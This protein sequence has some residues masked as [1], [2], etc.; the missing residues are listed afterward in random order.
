MPAAIGYFVAAVGGWGAAIALVVSVAASAYA[1]IAAKRAQAGTQQERKQILRSATAPLNVIYGKNRSAG[2]LTFAEEAYLMEVNEQ[3]Q[4]YRGKTEVLFMVVTHAGHPL[5]KV[6]GYKLNDDDYNRL[7][8]NQ[9][10]IQTYKDGAEVSDPM[11]LKHSPSW[12]ADMI[13]KGIA[14]F[15]ARLQFD[16][17]LFPNGVPNINAL[18]WG[19]EIE[20]PRTGLIQWTDN[21]ALVMLHYLKTYLGYSNDELIIET[22]I[23]AANIC[24]EWVSLPDGA[25]QEARYR[26]GAEFNIDEEPS[27]ILDKMLATMG[28]EWVKVGG[29]L[30]LA[31]AA[32]YGPAV[33]DITEDDLIDAVELQPEVERQDAFNTVRGKFNDAAQDYIETDYPQVSVAEYVAEDGEEIISSLDLEFVQSPWQCQRL[34][35]IAIQRNRY[36]MQVKLPCNLR[37]FKCVPGTVI[38]LRLPGIGLDGVEC[39]VLDWEFSLENG[40]VLVVRRESAAM[41]N[42]AVGRPLEVPPLISSTNEVAAP[43]N[44]RFETDVNND[45]VSGSLHWSN[46]AMQLSHTV[47]KIKAG[48]TVVQTVQVP[49]P[50]ESIA[51]VG[52]AAG[53]YSL[54]AMAV[55]VSGRASPETALNITLAHPVAPSH[56]DVD[57]SSEGLT[58]M[59]H[60][61]DDSQLS[62]NTIFEF[63]FNVID[64]LAGAQRLGQGK[65]L[66]KQGLAPDTQYWFWIYTITPLGRSATPLGIVAR[67]GLVSGDILEHIDNQVS[68]KVAEATEE[69]LRDMGSLTDIRGIAE[70]LDA[71]ILADYLAQG[72]SELDAQQA[73][74]RVARLMESVTLLSDDQQSLAQAVTSLYARFDENAALVQ[75]KDRAQVGYSVKKDGSPGDATSPAAAEMF[76]ETWIPGRAL[77]DSVKLVGIVTESGKTLTVSQYFSALETA[78][79]ELK[80]RAFLG[81]DANGRTTGI[82]ITSDE[83]GETVFQAINFIGDAVSISN[84]DNPA[85]ALLYY[86]TQNKV[87]SVKG[88][89]ILGDGYVIDSEDAIRAKDGGR[90]ETRYKLDPN[91]PETPTGRHPVG[92]GTAMPNPTDKTQIIWASTAFIN[93]DDTLSIT[94]AIPARISGYQGDQGPQGV[95]GIAG[96]NGVTTYTWIK[97]ADSATGAGLSNDP[98]GKAYIGFAYNKTTAAESNTPSDYTWSLVKGEQ[99][100]QGVPGPKGADGVTTYT[101]IKY[102]D[103]SDGTG[104]YDT[105]TVNTKYIGIAVNKT[106]QAESENKADYVWSQFKGDQGAQGLPGA[107]GFSG[108]GFYRLINSNGIWPGD[109]AAN[110]LFYTSFGRYPVIDDVLTFYNANGSTY[111]T[112]RCTDAGNGSTAKWAAAALLLHGDMIA[113]G[114][115]SGSRL[116]AGTEISAPFIRGGQIEIGGVNGT[117]GVDVN[118]GVLIKSAGTNAR[119]EIINDRLQVYDDTGALAVRIGRL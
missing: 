94:W 89:M 62:I 108:A 60:I 90:W 43:T 87:L 81:I 37:G 2:T 9:A 53:N 8:P 93:A 22:F 4:E 110:G 49:S 3:G 117:F 118:G 12:R 113:L 102:S 98:T 13:G 11:L 91:S 77:A 32:Y 30:G 48:E 23:S 68:Q 76:G 28:G 45:T 6:E 34:A 72:L 92:W 73:A 59:P 61:G 82:G 55:A 40:V 71:Q 79:G 15:V 1:V 33:I 65:M 106:V 26:I 86:D 29:R 35:H 97:Y 83:T 80:A 78:N 56:A 101:W 20:D 116:I 39:R 115:I 107:N 10:L 104:L 42:D 63:Y 103:N 105:P 46:S 66:T 44:L 95:P 41:Y 47:I 36:G 84:P 57:V 112:K 27:S 18:K 119:M 5:H 67:T 70:D 7:S 64:D 31:V 38:N 74:K 25:G 51:V 14:W 16:Q 54:S 58:I 24:D 21:P 100:N 50:G 85:E 75:Q 17:N 99:G 69:L 96:A 114:T 19:Y 52:L 111:T 109:G 88:R